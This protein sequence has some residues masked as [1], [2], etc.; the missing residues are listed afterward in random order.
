M[1]D[2]PA[3]IRVTVGPDGKT[4]EW[5]LVVRRD[6]PVSP[7]EIVNMVQ[8]FSSSLRYGLPH[9]RGMGRSTP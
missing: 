8:Q 2:E 5:E 9:V 4:P 1:S 3:Y 7:H 6:G